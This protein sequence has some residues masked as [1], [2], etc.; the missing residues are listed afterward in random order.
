MAQAR[1][2]TQVHVK[3]AKGTQMIRKGLVHVDVGDA[4]SPGADV[5]VRVYLSVLAGFPGHFLSG[6]GRG[7]VLR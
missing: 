7:L 3:Q 5:L 1:H 4:Q 6:S 2:P